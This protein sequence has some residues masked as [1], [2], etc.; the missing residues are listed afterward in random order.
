LRIK[1]IQLLSQEVFEIRGSHLL[2][3]IHYRVRVRVFKKKTRIK[4]IRN[5]V[6]IPVDLK[7]VDLVKAF[8]DIGNISRVFEILDSSSNIRTTDA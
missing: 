5:S 7:I 2:L 4:K 8:K 1:S 3:V 6:L